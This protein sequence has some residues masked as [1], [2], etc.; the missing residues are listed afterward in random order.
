MGT[1]PPATAAD[2]ELAD[3]SL[4]CTLAVMLA[5]RSDPLVELTRWFDDGPRWAVAG[6]VLDYDDLHVPSTTTSASSA[7]RRPS[8]PGA[9]R[10]L[11]WLPQA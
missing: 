6:H 2:C 4:R 10:G 11:I 9:A 5:A 1:R 7:C 8:P 3:R